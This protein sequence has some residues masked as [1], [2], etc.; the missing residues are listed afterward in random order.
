V[1]DGGAG[2]YVAVFS[3]SL[4]LSLVLTP[5]ALKLAIHRQVFDHPGAHKGHE[6]PVPYLG[7]LAMVGSF[8]LAVVL[9]A[10]LRP[11]VTGRGELFVMLALAFGLSMVGLLDDLRHLPPWI[12]LLCEIGAGLVLFES[13]V[14]V[15]LFSSDL[16]NV[17]FTIAWVV[18]ITNAIN[19]LDN[20]DGLSAGVAALG[21]GAFFVIAAANGQF[22]VAGLA[23]ATAGCAIGFLRHNF[24]PARIYMGDSGSL[25]LGFL[26]AYLGLKLRFDGPTN[27]TFLVPILVLSV[28]I[29]D[30]T[31]V[32]VCRL[33]RRRSPFQ[34]GRDHASHRL[35]AVGIPVPVAVSLIYVAAVSVGV[36][37]FVVSR[38]DRAPAYWLAGLA[39]ALAVFLGVLLARVPVYEV[40]A[41]RSRWRSRRRRAG[42]DDVQEPDAEAG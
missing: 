22:L 36:V 31:L 30:T 10:V 20:M 21:S 24:H 26:L 41:A 35:V 14:A 32:T 9:V 5:L 6:S 39:C 17:L 19:L 23:A 7:G 8:T 15:E 28:A 40:E 13:G 29:F 25:F 11:P 2:F 37:G 38:A 1:T 12:R 42:A 4:L 34:G 27:V 33:L 16:A 18:A 3:G